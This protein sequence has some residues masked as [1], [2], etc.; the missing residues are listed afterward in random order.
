MSG[1]LVGEVFDAREA[2]LLDD[3]TQGQLLALVAIAEKCHHASRQGSVR[4]SRIAAVM[5]KSESTAKRAVKVLRER[6]R[7]GLVR[8]VKG[9]YV[10]HGEGHANV[11]EL[12]VQR[13]PKV[14]HA[15]EQVQGSPKMTYASPD[16]QGPNRDV[17]RSS[18][19]VH[20]S[21]RPSAEVT[22][23]DPHDGLYDGINDGLNDGA[24]HAHARETADDGVAVLFGSL[25]GKSSAAPEPPPSLP[26]IRVESQRLDVD[27]AYGRCDVCATGLDENGDCP[28]CRLREGRWRRS[29]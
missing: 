17:H 24:A 5:G 16:V 15:S 28:R 25:F 26:P 1:Q 18:G 19:D 8:V 11:Y 10:S 6:E 2:G 3:L 22:Q 27:A 4:M 14:T 7:G 20:R 13:S 9:G 21:K 29:S 12:L 23:D